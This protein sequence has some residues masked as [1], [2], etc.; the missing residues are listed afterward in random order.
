[1]KFAAK[2]QA[3]V[4]TVQWKGDNLTEIQTFM[5][6]SSPL[7][8][9]DQLRDHPGTTTKPNIGIQVYTGER[10]TLFSL[11]H[12]A[13]GSWIVKG[14]IGFKIMSAEEFEELY[15]AVPAGSEVSPADVRPPN[16]PID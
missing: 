5:Y 6:P 11:Q 14:P 7:F 13:I 12:P 16:H 9:A 4:S 15:E 8:N 1:M 10:Y 3:R 2:A